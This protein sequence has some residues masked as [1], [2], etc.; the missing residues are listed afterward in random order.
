MVH[1]LLKCGL[2]NFEHYFASV[3]DECNC[4]VVW[5][6]F[7]VAFLWDRTE[8]WPFPVLWHCWVFQ[9][10]WHIECSNFTTSS[11][12]IWNSSAGIS[13]LPLALFVVML[14]KTHLTSNSRMSGS[15]WVMTSMVIWVIK[16]NLQQKRS[17]SLFGGLLLEWSTTP[18]WIPVKPLH[19]WG[20]LS[21]S[22][23]CTEI[24]NACTCHWS[25]ESA[26]FFSKTMSNHTSH[27][28]ASKIGWLDYEVLAHLP[29]SP[30]LSPTD[31]HFLKHLN[32]FLQGK[33]FHNQ[34]DAE[35]AFQAF[36]HFM[37]WE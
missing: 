4:A 26:Q 20:V 30:D 6:L 22:I 33:H 29:Y 34:Q 19:L 31:S 36:I 23:R 9:I 25:I 14:P 15:R 28:N 16:P 7:G 5:T 2:E 35:N 17:W 32:N 11:F 27:N 3:W 8:N 24:C 10:C 37:L 18:F 1:I 12:R 21:K 13:S